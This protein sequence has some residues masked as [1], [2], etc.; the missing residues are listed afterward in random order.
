RV[1]CFS[2]G[3]SLFKNLF[4]VFVPAKNDFVTCCTTV[5]NKEIPEPILGYLI[6]RA[7]RP[8][9][10]AVVFQTQSGVFCINGRAPWVR[11]KIVPACPP[12]N[13]HLLALMSGPSSSSSLD[14]SSFNFTSK[15]LRE[16]LSVS[17]SHLIIFMT[18]VPTSWDRR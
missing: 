11:A 18:D 13:F 1:N 8:C 3:S 14:S 5:S 10:N 12:L 4:V 17:L 7:N 9:V 6:Q 16:L 15:F 2:V